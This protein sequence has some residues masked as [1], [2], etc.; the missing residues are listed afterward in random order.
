MLGGSEDER[1]ERGGRLLNARQGRMGMEADSRWSRYN[2]NVN[3]FEGGS[4]RAAGSSDP[5]LS[6]KRRARSMIPGGLN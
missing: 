4:P 3:T 2:V 6:V 5:R 1:R